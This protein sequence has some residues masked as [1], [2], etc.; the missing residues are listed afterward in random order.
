MDYKQ[1]YLKYKKKYL[2][3]KSQL[4]GGSFEDVWKG[5][6]EKI[7][8]EHM[9]ELNNTVRSF[10]PDFKPHPLTSTIDGIIAA[11]AIMKTPK[12]NKE[13]KGIQNREKQPKWYKENPELITIHNNPK[14]F[15]AFN[16]LM[17]EINEKIQLGD[18]EIVQQEKIV[19]QGGREKF[20]KI[21]F[22][23]RLWNLA[24]G[25][26]LEP[27]GLTLLIS[28]AL[29]TEL[30]LSLV[31]SGIGYAAMPFIGSNDA[32]ETG[33][34]MRKKYIEVVKD[35]AKEIFYDTTGIITGNELIHY[36]GWGRPVDWLGRPI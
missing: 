24:W 22:L 6:E 34:H 2:Q 29:L 7:T 9:I 27:L 3:L 35:M 23:K 26:S 30:P 19:Q 1:K 17:I 14:Y 16:K 36:D 20:R 18:F 10:K 21:K 5:L 13:Y 33:K 4:V 15:D 11:F 8:N 12:F 32:I 28:S 25:I 31:I